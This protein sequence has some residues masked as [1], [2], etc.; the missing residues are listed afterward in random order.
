MTNEEKVLQYFFRVR[1][2]QNG[3][4]YGPTDGLL[5]AGAVSTALDI[6]KASVSTAMAHLAAAG[7]LTR[8][9]RGFYELPAADRKTTKKAGKKKRPTPQDVAQD[10]VGAQYGVG[11]EPS[12]ANIEADFSTIVVDEQNRRVAA[13]A[14]Y[15]W[16]ESH[17]WTDNTASDQHIMIEAANLG[18]GLRDVW[19]A[20]G[21]LGVETIVVDDTHSL[22]FPRTDLLL[23]R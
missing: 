22:R 20:I 15:L 11:A 10:I 21:M 7:D 17:T 23:S 1:D 4:P 3:L 12:V 19:Q 14:V 8:V 16:L 6:P 5:T 2:D 13:L 9:Q 18:Y